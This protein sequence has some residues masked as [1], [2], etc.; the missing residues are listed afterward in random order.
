M[1]AVILRTLDNAIVAAID[2][3]GVSVV[4]ELPATAQGDWSE[5]TAPE[6]EGL[7]SATMFDAYGIP[8]FELVGGIV[9]QRGPTARYWFCVDTNGNIQG[10]VFS[11]RGRTPKVPPSLRLVECDKATHD[12]VDGAAQYLPDSSLPRWSVDGSD[13]VIENLDPRLVLVVTAAETE[14]EVGVA[15]SW[16]FEIQDAGGAVVN[17][18]GQRRLRIQYVPVDGPPENKIAS[19]AFTSGQASVNRVLAAGAWTVYSH[20]PDQ[21]RVIGDVTVSVAE[22]W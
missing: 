8:Q 11:H 3:P 19:V 17:F 13:N 14:L 7:Q 18:T 15:A 21:Y 10:A 12:M 4:G 9:T 20:E 6:F 16:S 5:I 2:A 1:Y 22:A